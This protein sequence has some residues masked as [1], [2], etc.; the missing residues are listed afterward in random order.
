MPQP[1]NDGDKPRKSLKGGY[2]EYIYCTDMVSHATSSFS[3][4]WYGVPCLPPHLVVPFSSDWHSVPH[5]PHLVATDM[6]F[7]TY[8]PI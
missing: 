5:L 1:T 4:N 8:L 2:V 7:H 6:V 3:S